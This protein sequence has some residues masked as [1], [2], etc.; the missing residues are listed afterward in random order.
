M[1]TPPAPI[2]SE[3][4]PP[5]VTIPL[6]STT[7]RPYSENADPVVIVRFELVASKR[8]VAVLPG[9]ASPDQFVVVVHVA[10][11]A[12]LHVCVVCASAVGAGHA[13]STTASHT[14]TL[15][16]ARKRLFT[17]DGFDIQAR[18]CVISD[19]DVPRP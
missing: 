18:L 15:A 1:S 10:F 5:I 14:N 13:N 7:C 8:T 19:C 11:V 16:N 2:V 3:L 12:P 4:E 9:M 17:F 6:G